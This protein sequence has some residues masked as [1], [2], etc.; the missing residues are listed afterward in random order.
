MASHSAWSEDQLKVLA[1]TFPAITNLTIGRCRLPSLQSLFP[2]FWRDLTDINLSQSNITSWDQ[3]TPLDQ[4][5]N[6]VKITLCRNPLSHIPEFSASY[7]GF[8]KLSI[9]NLKMCTINDMISVHN[10]NGLPALVRLKMADTAI[11][12]KFQENFRMLAVS[13][14]PKLRYFNEGLVKDRERVTLE[15]QFLRDFCDPGN[16]HEHRNRS[17]PSLLDLL[18]DEEEALNRTVFTRLFAAHGIVHK[19]AEV[20]L[21]PPVDALINF[22]LEGLETVQKRVPVKWTVKRLKAHVAKVFN[23]TV[24]DYQLWFGDHEIMHVQ[25]PTLLKYDNLKLHYVGFKDNDIVFIRPKKV[26]RC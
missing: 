22:E 19:F 6:L 5:P 25:G 17:N 1:Q 11:H 18:S 14:L 8:Q 4:L 7:T 9:L 13:Y 16:E 20:N 15:R 2:S 10:L 12:V 23:I 24:S 26:P 21:A 3:L